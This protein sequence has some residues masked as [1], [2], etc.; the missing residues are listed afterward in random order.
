MADATS[1]GSEET[2]DLCMTQAQRDEITAHF[3]AVHK[4]MLSLNLVKMNWA[5]AKGTTRDGREITH[6]FT[7]GGY[8]RKYPPG[9]GV[10]DVVGFCGGGDER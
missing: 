3:Q 10:E 8:V 7:I 6:K 9:Y 5:P 4:I 1:V 2:I